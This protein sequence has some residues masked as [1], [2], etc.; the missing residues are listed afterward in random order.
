MRMPR[1]VFEIVGEEAEWRGLNARSVR[2]CG[3]VMGGT[4]REVSSGR[5]R[6]ICIVE[7]MEGKPKR[8]KFAQTLLM[9]AEGGR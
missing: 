5:G 4:T 3:E 7:K 2:E 8:L 1:M 6:Q 9:H